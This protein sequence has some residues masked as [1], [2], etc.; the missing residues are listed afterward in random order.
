M[1][2]KVILQSCQNLQ[3]TELWKCLLLFSPHPFYLHIHVSC[4]IWGSLSQRC[5]W[6]FKSLGTIK[7]VTSY[8][9]AQ[10]YIAKDLNLP[11]P[12]QKS[13]LYWAQSCLRS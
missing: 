1:S 6:R 9:S 11:T 7:R 12:R 2:M 3:Q 13:S 4:E 5:C 8:Q 10:S